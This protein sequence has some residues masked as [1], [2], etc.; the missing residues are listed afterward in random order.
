MDRILRLRQQFSHAIFH[1]A[2]LGAAITLQSR[3]GGCLQPAQH[4]GRSG[5]DHG[6]LLGLCTVS[7]VVPG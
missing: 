1:A 7:A 5:W 2:V 3:A 4:L 6:G